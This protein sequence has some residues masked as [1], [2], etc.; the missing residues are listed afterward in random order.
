MLIVLA[1]ATR[2][3]AQGNAFSVPLGGRS[4]LMGNTGTALAVDGAAPFLNPASI[5]R[6]DA[7]GFAFSVNFYS[8]SVTNFSGWH[9]PGPVDSAKFGNL[10]LDN[11][12][13]T[14]SGFN[15]VPSTLCVF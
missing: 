9:Q 3:G 6:L 4:A 2:A 12:G 10:G 5:V 14:A 1:L 11:T 8:Y 7:H 15:A 13:V